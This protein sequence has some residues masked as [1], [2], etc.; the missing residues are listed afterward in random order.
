MIEP[1]IFALALMFDE[2]ISAILKNLS[3]GM[4]LTGPLILVA[5]I[6]LRGFFRSLWNVVLVYPAKILVWFLF[7]LPNK[8]SKERRM[9]RMIAS[10]KVR[11]ANKLRHSNCVKSAEELR[12]ANKPRHSNYVKSAIKAR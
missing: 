8:K 10:E 11:V 2:Q 9:A 6:N 3:Y 5:G 7:T 1:I 4:F 12:V